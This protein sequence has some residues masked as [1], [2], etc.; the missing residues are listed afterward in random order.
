MAFIRHHPCPKCNSR[1]NLGEFANGFYCF[2]C[3]YT[4]PKTDNESLRSRIEGNKKK[5]TS[6]IM[7]E[8][9]PILPPIALKWLL[10][11]G[12]TKQEIGQFTWEQTKNL[13]VLYN[14]ESYWQ[15]RNFNEKVS[16]KYLSQ[17]KKPLLFYEKGAIVQNP[18]NKTLVFVEDIV[19]AVKVS[20]FATSSPLLRATIPLETIL[21]CLEHDFDRVLIWMDRD[22]AKDSLKASKQASQILGNVQRIVTELD[23]KCLTDKEIK[24]CLGLV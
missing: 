6:G 5:E 21:K 23:P 19:S 9:S 14:S 22:K 18:K 1:D 16:V 20:R 4:I 13:L 7:L 10:S 15:G 3:R 24:E 11:Y 12:L 17:G 8:T 2:G